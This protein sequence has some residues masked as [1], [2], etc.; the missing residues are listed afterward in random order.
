MLTLPRHSATGSP[1]IIS[2][3]GFDP[4]RIFEVHTSF[5]Q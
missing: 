1:A 2:A 4:K 5:V 3:H